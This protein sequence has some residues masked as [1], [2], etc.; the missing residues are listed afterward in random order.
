MEERG[1]LDGLQ[2]VALCATRAA[3]YAASLLRDLGAGVGVVTAM[4]RD[5]VTEHLAR[6]CLRL[7]ED[8]LPAAVRAA[9]ALVVDL[10]EGHPLL[11]AASGASPLVRL[12]WSREAGGPASDLSC[13]AA[14]GVCDVIGEPER[15]PLFLP[16][17]VG[18]FYLGV[19]GAAALVA[20]LLLRAQRAGPDGAVEVALDE[21]WAHAVGSNAMLYE[22]QGI[23]Y[24][25]AGRRAP[26][27]GGPYPYALY[28]VRDGE[29]CL[30]AR[31]SRDFRNFVAAMGNPAWAAQPRYRDLRAM[32]REYPDE[33]D[34]LIVPWLAQR[35]RDDLGRLAREF[36]FPCAPVRTP[37]EALEDRLLKE[38]RFWLD[39]GGLRLPGPL[40]REQTWRTSAVAAKAARRKGAAP[41]LRGWRI[42]D[43]SWVWAGPMI[44][45]L[46]ADLGAE[47]IK[48]EHPDR[49]DNTRLRGRPLKNGTPVA[50]DPREL[51][52]Y[53]HNL[54]R[55][56]RSAVIDIKSESGRAELLRL[57]A[58]S[59]VVLESF[60]P[61]VLTR[62]GLGY[63][64]LRAVNPAII[65][66][67]M[68]GAALEETALKM[69]SYA[70]VTSSLAGL[71][72]QIGYPG[73]DPTGA[74]AFGFS[75]PN[76]GMHGA[77]FV[78]AAM[79]ARGRSGCGAWVRLSQLETLCA[80]LTEMYAVAQHAPLDA[81][82]A[83]MIAT[84]TG[85]VAAT[86]AGTTEVR[87]LEAWAAGRTAAEVVAR[88]RAQG[89]ACAAVEPVAAHVEPRWAERL[90]DEVVHPQY[91]A[92]Q[93]YR[94]P[95]HGIPLHV[96]ASA[97]L[98]G[99]Y[100]AATS[101]KS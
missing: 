85:Y 101:A 16:H 42:L 52:P 31:A 32:G 93:L 8:A 62:L 48:I 41:D 34:A 96:R 75:D 100:R 83:A 72:Q 59:D 57:V 97:P 98:L 23:P 4:P 38:Q 82:G 79:V 39:D 50:G 70:P 60:S 21:A 63:E 19:H 37:S 28:P 14:A 5:A 56:K 15:E 89:I 55:G 67:S 91:G 10:P 46:L 11:G 81:P 86:F 25:R 49:L 6:R 95:W 58:A 2:I 13:Q 71:E 27:C 92:E 35:T 40:V 30:I 24:T 76:A 44:G 80:V 45:A 26:G 88:L 20:A 73:E 18:E 9:D 84:T 1:P 36:S 78:L 64:D 99:E 87:E 53:F 12:R 90:L 43:L 65:V 33:V 61:G 22:S 94:F 51:D 69:P 66:F 7:D 29:V 77:L 47:V 3:L 54:N 68:R 74:M 17:R